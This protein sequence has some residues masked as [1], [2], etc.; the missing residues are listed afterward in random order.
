MDK[1]F[2]VCVPRG[3]N[4]GLGQ[5]K[6]GGIESNMDEYVFPERLSFKVG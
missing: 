1:S 5:K 6:S 3:C 2:L 4:L